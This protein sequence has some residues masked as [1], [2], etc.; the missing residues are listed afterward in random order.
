MVAGLAD[1]RAIATLQAAL[2]ERPWGEVAI[3]ALLSEAT[4]RAFLALE[5]DT[6]AAPVA[7]YVIA[8]VVLDEA[9]ILTIGVAKRLQ[10]RRIGHALL[11]ALHE[12]AARESVR[13]IFLEVAADNAAARGLY[14][15]CGYRECGHRIGYY[16]R[17]GGAPADAIVLARNVTSLC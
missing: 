8:R 14:A 9:E 17:T 10:G 12:Q 6:D 5:P 15:R 11:A 2:F 7:G 1:S 16:A 3:D 4:T 13:R